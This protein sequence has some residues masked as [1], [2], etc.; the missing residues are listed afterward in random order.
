MPHA[1]DVPFTV[2]CKRPIIH[3]AVPKSPALHDW[4]MM[5]CCLADGS[6][7]VGRSRGEQEARR[8]KQALLSPGEGSLL[9]PSCALTNGLGSV[10]ARREEG[11]ECRD[12]V[13]RWRCPKRS[14][15]AA[16]LLCAFLISIICPRGRGHDDKRRELSPGC[17]EPTPLAPLWVD[18]RHNR[19]SV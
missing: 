16:L 3:P 4:A 13:G 18:S 9:G 10:R 2:S 17:E 11:S 6:Q 15:G 5:P 1:T 7:Q 12:M 14:G 8:G 19:V